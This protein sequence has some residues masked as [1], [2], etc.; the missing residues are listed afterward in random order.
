MTPTIKGMFV[1][2]HIA[3]LRKH[4]GE[5]AIRDL[6]TRYGTSIIF[7]NLQDVPVRDEVRIIE[8][9]LDLLGEAPE[10]PTERAFDA[11]RL[12]LRNFM[13]TTFGRIIST[14]LPK[15]PDGYRMLLSR[16]GYIARHVFKNSNFNSNVEGDVL[17]IAMD[18]CDYPIDHFRGFF[19]EWM[20]SWGIV[21][22]RVSARERS[23]QTF[24]YSMRIV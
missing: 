22:P 8:I 7:K 20:H 11:G 19:T 18:N 3:T 10:D 14:A 13:G 12:H 6:E 16:S 1:N 17:I 4:K 23:P 5:S 21:D 2:S 15:S 9:V 24:E